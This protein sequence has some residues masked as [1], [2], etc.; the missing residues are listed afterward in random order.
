[1]G[2]TPEQIKGRIKSVAKQNNADARTLMRI[3]MM[4]RFLERL[5]QSE[6][7]E[8]GDMAACVAVNEQGK[9]VAED[10]WNG[11][12]EDFQEAVQKYFSEKWNMPK[13]EDVVSEIIEKAVPVP[14]NSA[15]DYSDVPV[16]YEPF[17]YAK[18]N[19]EVDLYRTSYRLNSECKQAIHGCVNNVPKKPRRIGGRWSVL[20]RLHIK[21]A[22]RRQKDNAP[23]QE[24]ERSRKS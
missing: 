9:L 7:E 11:F 16:Y 5:A 22:E 15:Q 6:Y 13:K 1:M 10:L 21:Q 24:Q 8:H 2:F 23:Q 19:D 17:S 4:E 18:E 14:D 3:Y 20:D 12:D